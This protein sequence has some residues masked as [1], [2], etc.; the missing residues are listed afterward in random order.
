MKKIFGIFLISICLASCAKSVKVGHP[1]AVNAFDS[2]TYDALY[3]IGASIEKAR[4]LVTTKFP[5]FKTQFNT[6]NHSFTAL[7]DSYK[8]YH[9]ALT[10]GLSPASGDLSAQLAQVVADISSLLTSLGVKK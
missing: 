4:E 8:A 1:G 7:E 10:Q 9:I 3:T 2:N 6:V 5:Q